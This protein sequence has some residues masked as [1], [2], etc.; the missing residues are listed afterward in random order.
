MGQ[1]TC[2]LIGH[3][4][5]HSISPEVHR[6]L[7]ALSGTQGSY[8]LMD[9]PPEELENHLPALRALDGF[10]VTI[11]YKQSLLPLLDM[12]DGRAARYGAVNT[13]KRTGN[14]LTGFNTDVTG[15]LRA[16]TQADIPLTGNVLLC[17]TGGVAH[18]MACEALERGCAL[19]VGA[20]TYGKASA[21]ADELTARYPGSR[22][23]PS[24]LAYLSGSFDLILNGTPVG[25]YP[26][27]KDIPVPLNVAR[28]AR[29]VFD[30]IYNPT[31]TA[32]LSRVRAAGAKV[33]NGL[34]MLVWQAAAAQEIWTGKTFSPE[35]I[36]TLCHDMAAYIKEHFA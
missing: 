11:P 20:R 23:E 21:F 26:D 9:F 6:R 31:E 5:G 3:P 14:G 24:A 36:D 12:V 30:T 8:E 19:T 28:S 17:G 13:I 29:A 15:F 34:A 16:L 32:L 1:F 27:I 35:D 10:N 7:F 22:V 2:G 25:M 4:L 33:Q 18:M